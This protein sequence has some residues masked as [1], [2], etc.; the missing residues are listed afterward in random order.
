MG[1]LV[2]S[3]SPGLWL[4]LIPNKLADQCGGSELFDLRCD[5]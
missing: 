3:L 1:L 5:T 4:A 2:E